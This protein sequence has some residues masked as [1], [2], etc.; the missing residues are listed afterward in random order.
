MGVFNTL[1]KYGDS[2]CAQ[3]VL[4]EK[5][6]VGRK[7]KP[8]VIV[9]CDLQKHKY[10]VDHMVLEIRKALLELQLLS[11]VDPQR[12]VFPRKAVQVTIA[13]QVLISPK[14]TT[15]SLVHSHTLMHIIL[16]HK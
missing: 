12:Q 4:E 15:H 8:Q 1:P 7:E 5:A 13:K 6:G 14:A 9:T 3:Q 11:H 10:L 2:P 16:S